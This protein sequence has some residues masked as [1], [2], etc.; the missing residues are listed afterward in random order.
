[1]LGV[2]LSRPSASMTFRGTLEVLLAILKTTSRIK[3]ALHLPEVSAKYVREE[4]DDGVVPRNNRQRDVTRIVTRGHL[5]TPPNT[6][7]QS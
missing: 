3:H 2:D 1:M 6:T 7:P 5:R 4:P